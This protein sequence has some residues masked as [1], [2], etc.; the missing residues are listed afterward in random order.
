MRVL[1]GAA[2]VLALLLAQPAYAYLDPGT[3]SYFLQILAASIL[4]ALFTLKLFWGRLK[5]L[6]KKLF[7]RKDESGFPPSRE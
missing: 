6:L 4:G 5:T 1:L 3:G 2:L 7:Q